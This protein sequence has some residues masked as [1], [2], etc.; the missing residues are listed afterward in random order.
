MT[1]PATTKAVFAAAPPQAGRRLSEVRQIILDAA[2]ATGLS[3]LTETLKWGQLAFLTPQKAGTT[4]RL[5]LPKGQADNV[6]LYVHCQTDLVAR[7]RVL[8]PDEFAYEENRAVLIPVTGAFPRAALHQM[9]AMALS[10]HRDKRSKVG[11]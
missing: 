10:Y 6:A 8:Y 4:I 5:G 7:W 1:L 9:A 2:E 11:A 3:P